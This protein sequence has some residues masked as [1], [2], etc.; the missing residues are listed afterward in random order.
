MTDLVNGRMARR[1]QAGEKWIDVCAA[2]LVPLDRGVAVL[3]AGVP[4]AL[5]RLS[6]GAGEQGEEW[7]AVS[8]IDPATGAPTMARGL[9]GS[10]GDP[11]ARPT[12]AAPLHKQRYDLRTGECLDDD[13]LRV[14]VYPVQVRDGRVGVS[15]DDNC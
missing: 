10:T 6:A 1:G 14:A 2:E 8:H 13:R 12:V 5:F 7:F 11:S 4:I 3:A 15:V 9:V